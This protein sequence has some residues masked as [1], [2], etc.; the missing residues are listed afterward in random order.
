[1]T[2]PI[3]RPEFGKKRMKCGYCG[4]LK[5]VGRTT[6]EHKA[7]VCVDCFGPA[8]GN[9]FGP[10]KWQELFSHPDITEENG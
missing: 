2:R 10:M 3:P 6:V 4:S 8:I 7:Y 9:G 1:M 5:V